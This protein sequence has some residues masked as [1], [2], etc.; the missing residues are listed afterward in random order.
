MQHAQFG[1]RRIRRG[2][3]A[4]RGPGRPEAGGPARDVEGATDWEA[5]GG[6]GFRG[7]EEG[8]VGGKEQTWQEGG[9]V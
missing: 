5:T 8:V 4:R 2:V 9:R 7:K 1:G 3:Q 6:G